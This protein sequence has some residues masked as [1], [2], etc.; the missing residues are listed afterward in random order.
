MTEAHSAEAQIKEA[1]WTYGGWFVLLSLTLGAGVALGYL[2]WGDAPGLRAQVA[3]L[4][5]KVSAA[6]AERENVQTQL[7]MTREENRRCEA[8]VAAQ[9]ASPAASAQPPTP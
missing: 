9:S 2:L 4:T 1:A 6:R 5:Q 7:T 8:K 3:D